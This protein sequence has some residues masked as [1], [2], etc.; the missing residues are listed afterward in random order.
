ME[1]EFHFEEA[2]KPENWTREDV[3]HTPTFEALLQEDGTLYLR[4]VA[5][6][7]GFSP[8]A[9]QALTRFLSERVKV[10]DLPP[11][12]DFSDYTPRRVDLGDENAE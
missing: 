2:I 1:D 7:E 12:Y 8:E 9:V 5:L 11:P 6:H 3:L 4:G 10:P